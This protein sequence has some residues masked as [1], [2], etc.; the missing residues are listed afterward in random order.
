MTVDKQIKSI[1][2][3][4]DNKLII[5]TCDNNDIVVCDPYAQ[6]IIHT[7]NG[8]YCVKNVYCYPVKNELEKKLKCQN[9]Q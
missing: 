9:Y 6:K 7:F 2:C 3:S 1:Q 5:V 8:F 4:I